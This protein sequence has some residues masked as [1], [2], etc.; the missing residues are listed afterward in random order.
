MLGLTSMSAEEICRLSLCTHLEQH[1]VQLEAGLGGH[2]VVASS[3]VAG[4]QR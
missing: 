4:G 3:A 2:R 1:L